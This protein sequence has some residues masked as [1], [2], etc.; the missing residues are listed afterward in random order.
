M[1]ATCEK[2]TVNENDPVVLAAVEGGGTSFRVSICEVSSDSVVPTILHRTQIDSSHS[3]PHWTLD[4]CSRF[5]YMHK[6]PAGYHALGLA[7]FGPVGVHRS[8]DETYG[9]ILNSSP[10]ATW[11]GVNLLKPLAQACEGS[12]TLH[13]MVDTDVNAPA[14]AEYKH[15]VANDEK[16]TSVAYVTVGTGTLGDI[17]DIPC[18]AL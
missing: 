10:K 9:C 8:D 13:I 4:E 2:G 12:R 11:R 18:R 15:A 5:L 16:I 6:P 1:T 7:T 3:D 14:L 17:R